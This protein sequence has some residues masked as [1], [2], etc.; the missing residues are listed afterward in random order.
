MGFGVLDGMN[1]AGR[2]AT[3]AERLMEDSGLREKFEETGEISA[4]VIVE[5]YEFAFTLRRVKDE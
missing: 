3:V 5:G 2:I 4:K 1:A